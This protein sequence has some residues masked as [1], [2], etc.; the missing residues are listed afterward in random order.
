MPVDR[1][2]EV[3]S[4]LL[5]SEYRRP[6]CGDCRHVTALDFRR[7][8]LAWVEGVSGSGGRRRR[9]GDLR[10]GLLDQLR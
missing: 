7:Q 6:S 1:A 2:A 9:G 10:S 4:K 5:S 8:W 3:L